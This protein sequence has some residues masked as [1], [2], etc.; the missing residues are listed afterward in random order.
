MQDGSEV[1]DSPQVYQYQQP[2]YRTISMKSLTNKSSSQSID[3][4]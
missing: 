3:L 2:S 4:G 1:S